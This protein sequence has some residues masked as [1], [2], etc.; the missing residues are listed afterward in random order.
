MKEL[1][2]YFIKFLETKADHPIC[3]LLD[4]LDQLRDLGGV[5]SQWVPKE[6]GTNVTFI[7]SAIPDEEYKVVP[8]LKV[9]CQSD[10][11]TSSWHQ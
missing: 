10:A 7:L 9:F 11:H 1:Q 3:F 4:S 6:L 8:T 5:L 2:E